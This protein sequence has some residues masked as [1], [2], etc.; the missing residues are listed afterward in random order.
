[1][2]VYILQFLFTLCSCLFTFYSYCLHFTTVCLHFT[3]VYLHFTAVYLHFTAVCFDLRN[4]RSSLRSRILKRHLVYEI[5]NIF[6]LK[7]VAL[8][9][10]FGECLQTFP[11][12]TTAD[13]LTL[14]FESRRPDEIAGKEWSSANND[15]EAMEK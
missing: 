15:K 9:I 12:P 11:H 7:S 13:F 3:A 6:F 2:F 1:M 4:K 10:M 14:G 8:P 5:T